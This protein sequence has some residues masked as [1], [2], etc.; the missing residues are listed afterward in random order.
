MGASGRG[1]AA[2]LAAAVRAGAADARQRGH[3]AAKRAREA[4]SIHRANGTPAFRSLARVFGGVAEAVTV[5]DRRWRVVF[6]NQRGA[7]MWAAGLPPDALLGRDVWE[8]HPGARTSR[9][10]VELHRAM[11][12]RLA[13]TFE[14]PSPHA[15][16]CVQIRAVPS[17]DG[18]IVYSY[19]VEEGPA[20]R[21]DRAMPATPRRR[22]ARTERGA[23]ARERVFHALIENGRDAVL[24]LDREGRVV[25]A[26]RH[27]FGGES[28]ARSSAL[29]ADVFT[30]LHPDDVARARR[31]FERLR[32][33]PGRRLHASYRAR[34]RRERWVWIEGSGHNLLHDPMVKAIVVS[35]RDVTERR[36]AEAAYRALG[37]H[38]FQ[39]QA[40]LQGGRLVFA[41]DVLARMTGYTLDELYALGAEQ[42]IELVH[43]DD[44]ER[45]LARLRERHAGRPVR[46]SFTCRYV[47]KNGTVRWVECQGAPIDYRGAPA[48]QIALLDVTDAHL[49]EEAL[50]RSEQHYRSL[51]EG[52]LDLVTIVDRRGTLLYASPS[53]ERV[54]GWRPDEIVGRSAFELLDERDREGVRRDFDRALAVS[55]TVRG[56]ECRT[57][58]KD[59]SLRVIECMAHRSPPGAPV[60]GLI[61]NARDVTERKAA[62]ER[63]RILLDLAR[64]LASTLDPSQILEQVCRRVASALGCDMVATYQWSDTEGRYRVTSQLGVPAER[65]AEV[66]EFSFGSGELFEGQLRAGPL[67]F[68]DANDD[69]GPL[70]SISRW[71]GVRAVALAPLRSSA[72]HHG[73]LIAAASRAGLRFDEAHGELLAAIAGQLAIALERAQLYR[74]Q[75]AAADMFG[76]LARVGQELLAGFDLPGLPDRLCRVSS[77]VLGGAVTHVLVHLPAEN[78]FHVVAA[79]GVAAEALEALR[80]LRVPPAVLGPLCALLREE[81]CAAVVVGESSPAGELASV[82]GLPSGTRLLVVPLL[83]SGRIVGIETAHLAPGCCFEDIH[84][85]IA[86]GVARLGS[87]ALEHARTMEEL[88]RANRLKSDFMAMMSHELRTPLNVIL[89]YSDLL[90][91]DD[92][93]TLSPA[94]TDA[95]ERIQESGRHL[96]GL[97]T[98]VLDVTRL[99][100]GRIPLDVKEASIPGLV[101]ELEVETR[102]ASASTDVEFTTRVDPS[103]GSVVTDPAKLKLALKNL[104]ANAFKFTERGA[105]SLAAERDRDGVSFVVADTGIGIPEDGV[106]AIFEPF[107]QGESGYT[108]RYGGVGMGLYVVR[109][110]VEMLG[111]T[112]GATSRPGAGSSFRVWIPTTPPV[113]SRG[114]PADRRTRACP[115][116]DDV[117]GLPSFALLRERLAG[118]TSAGDAQHTAGALLCVDVRPIAVPWSPDGADAPLVCMVA[119]RLSA[120]LDATDTVAHTAGGE[121]LVLLPGR[122]ARQ[123]VERV[124]RRVAELLGTEF[125]L[126]GETLRL[127]VSIGSVVVAGGAQA[128]R[129]VA[130]ARAASARSRTGS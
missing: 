33:L 20:D 50:R 112:V 120:A 122:R 111:G 49:A 60:A 109:R 2:G 99:E 66:A 70:G 102:R 63:T 110:V 55:G 89:G 7:D 61:I 6:M 43:E 95:V 26:S 46:P 117:T 124:E 126:A 5:V 104:L 59:G 69:P 92:F 85:R 123:D 3:G 1:R 84:V 107:R 128:D 38:S 16:R 81:E 116:A 13:V 73:A 77:D 18:L 87:L 103:L 67:L 37:E 114:V 68:N 72:R 40:I 90:L 15:G 17:P 9:A 4:R 52:A 29:G 93:E 10:Y 51:I 62:E 27:V 64:D 12:E 79:H 42:A 32:D 113:G 36:D 24:M 121:F 91:S 106:E 108:R 74:R 11:R 115:S 34:H 82:L 76:A 57:R 41:N 14:Q 35:F 21:T 127:G 83:R 125:A 48:T 100:S 19:D 101:A 71:F 22:G 23:F 31:D 94:Q 130:D 129:I 25:Y 58:H 98:D 78:A 88:D 8:I 96:L 80:V 105:V 39:A 118:L 44:R 28:R 75:R 86:R 54:L 53:H 56:I 47:R 119:E 30:R 45:V 97:I 65:V